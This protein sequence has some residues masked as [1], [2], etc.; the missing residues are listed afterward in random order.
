MPRILKRP[1]FSRGGTT[2][3]NNGIMTGL[4][5]RKGFENGTEKPLTQAEI[6]ANEYYDQ[7]SKIQP[8]KPCKK[9]L[10]MPT[11]LQQAN[12]L[13]FLFLEGIFFVFL[14]KNQKYKKKTIQK[15]KKKEV[16]MDEVCWQ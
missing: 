16:C 15:K 14:I 13:F 9:K 7:L 2:K 10:L 6:Y 11:N 3:K 5:D 1:M 4:V 8:P 12:F